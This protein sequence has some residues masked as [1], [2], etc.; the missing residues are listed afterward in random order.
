M[1]ISPYGIR[2]KWRFRDDTDPDLYWSAGC[3][4]L[5][6]SL[7]SPG[8]HEPPVALNVGGGLWTSHESD[9]R[10][11]DGQGGPRFEFVLH[12]FGNAVDEK[13]PLFENIVGFLYVKLIFLIKNYCAWSLILT[14]C[15]VDEKCL[16]FTESMMDFLC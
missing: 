9:L 1:K 16:L 3:R 14:G 13:C 7:R 5:A 8:W 4:P 15:D 2:Q 11:I 12:V 10:L 6:H